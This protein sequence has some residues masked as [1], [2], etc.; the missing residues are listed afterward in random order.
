MPSFPSCRRPAVFLIGSD[1]TASVGKWQRN[2]APRRFANRVGYAIIAAA[3]TDFKSKG[4][5]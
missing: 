2:F 5:I 1:Y 3:D 4:L